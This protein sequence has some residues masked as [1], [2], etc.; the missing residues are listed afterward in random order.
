[1]VTGKLGTSR[2]PLSGQEI[3]RASWTWTHNPP[4]LHGPSWR[5]ESW[6]IAKP[7]V[8]Q[9]QNGR[10]TL[11][12]HSSLRQDSTLRVTLVCRLPGEHGHK[13]ERT[14]SVS[15]ATWSVCCTT[16]MKT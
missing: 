13:R 16:L 1:M 7:Q 15:M 9:T 5:E 8:T 11:S 12:P 4:T 3:H 6:P 2:H 14:Y 10:P